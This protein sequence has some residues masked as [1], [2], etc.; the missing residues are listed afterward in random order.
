M[1]HTVEVLIVDEPLGFDPSFRAALEHT[2]ALRTIG[3]ED[4]GSDASGTVVALICVRDA[5]LAAAC[6]RIIVLR[7]RQPLLRILVVFQ[8]LGSDDLRDLLAAGADAF[9]GRGTAARDV[10]GVILGLA[11]APTEVGVETQKNA[12][13]T[14]D[15]L[16]LTPREAE[17]LRFLSAGFSNK[18]VARRL[19]LSVRTVETHRLNLRRK[20]QTGR[21]KDLVMLARQLGLDPVIDADLPRRS[22]S[23]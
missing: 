2:P 14:P 15:A 23:H 9:V 11:G 17:V 6:E 4:L 16:T 10:C 8:S 3:E 20:T 7:E 19:S 21:L 13:T 18:E 22:A 5:L 12:Y 1:S